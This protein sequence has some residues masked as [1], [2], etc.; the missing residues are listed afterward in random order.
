MPITTCHSSLHQSP[1][2]ENLI[3]L[4]R[5]KLKNIQEL[6]KEFPWKK[7]RTC[8]ACG[9]HRLWGHGFVLRYFYDYY[10]GLWMKRWHCADCR[11]VH[12]VRPSDYTPGIHYRR[13]VQLSSLKAKLNGQP[14]F[15]DISRQ[16]QQHWV[17]IFHRLCRRESNWGDPLVLLDRLVAG[18][19][20]HLTNRP[21]HRKSWREAP[22]PYLSFALTTK[23]PYFS[24]E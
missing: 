22:P 19:Q 8:P 15:T 1:G 21:I 16:V 18:S 20:F 3:L 23:R 4:C 9:S 5:I 17:K 11:A 2:G 13:E 6:G 7:P 10:E 12:T 14:F 24:L